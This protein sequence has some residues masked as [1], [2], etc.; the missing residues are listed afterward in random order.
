MCFYLGI[1]PNKCPF[2]IVYKDSKVAKRDIVCYKWSDKGDVDESLFGSFFQDFTYIRGQLQ[3]KV[4]LFP[5][6][7]MINQGYHTLITNKHDYKASTRVGIFII[8]KGT[9]YHKNGSERVSETLIYVGPYTKWNWLKVK[10][11]K[12]YK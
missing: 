1:V 5:I 7:G 12:S 11:L 6:N 4:A 2:K 8:P 9:E 3:Q 10:F